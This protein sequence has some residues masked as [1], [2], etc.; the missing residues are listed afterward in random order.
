MSFIWGKSD[1][2]S[3]TDPLSAQLDLTHTVLASISTFCPRLVKLKLHM[4][5]RLDDSVLDEWGKGF[6]QLKYLTLF[7]ESFLA[8]RGI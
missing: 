2:I 1:V 4:C 7:G 3:P 8:Y 5:G 6:K